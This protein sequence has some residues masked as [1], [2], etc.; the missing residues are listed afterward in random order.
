[1]AIQP[2]YSPNS[3]TIKSMDVIREAFNVVFT[4]DCTNKQLFIGEHTAVINVIMTANRTWSFL[5][6]QPLK[7]LIVAPLDLHMP[8]ERQSMGFWTMT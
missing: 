3:G 7:T 8:S 2:L 5:A 4:V 1:M 6:I